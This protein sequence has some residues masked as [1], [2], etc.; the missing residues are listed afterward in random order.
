MSGPRVRLGRLLCSHYPVCNSAVIMVLFV[1]VCVDETRGD[2]V[3][4]CNVDAEWVTEL[5]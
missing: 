5:D 3:Q 2:M 4:P 1:C